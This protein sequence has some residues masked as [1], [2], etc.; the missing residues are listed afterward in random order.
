VHCGDFSRGPAIKVREVGPI[1]IAPVPLLPDLLESGR[2][3]LL[4]RT[5]FLGLSSETCLWT[6]PAS[7]ARVGRENPQFTSADV[8]E[9][10]LLGRCC[11]VRERLR[12]CL[13]AQVFAAFH[14]EV[15]VMVH[16]V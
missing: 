11:P 14:R 2:E 16:F 5:F 12:E 3:E 4:R 13:L 1:L 15:S 6:R 10:H 9:A 8:V 7:D